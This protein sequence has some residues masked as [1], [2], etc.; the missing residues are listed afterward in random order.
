[1]CF[2]IGPALSPTSLQPNIKMDSPAQTK[3]KSKASQLTPL[4]SKPL[5]NFLMKT[6]SRLS[7]KPRPPCPKIEL[8]PLQIEA[9]NEI[10]GLL[11]P[12]VLGNFLQSGSRESW[13]K[14]NE[15]V[16]ALQELLPPRP[17]IKP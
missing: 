5:A 9:I 14:I 16:T 10:A 15:F 8:T 2:L 11:H 1:M 4:S 3:A 7:L 13:A 12:P 17:T 6:D